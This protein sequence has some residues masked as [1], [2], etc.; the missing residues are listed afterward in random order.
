MLY[1]CYIIIM[2][3]NTKK[4]IKITAITLASLFLAIVLIVGGYVGYVLASFYRIKD[5]QVLEVNGT[6]TAT[7]VATEQTLSIVT[8]N[9]GFGA[10]V[11]EYDFFMDEGKMADGTFTVGSHAKGISKKRVQEAVTG[12]ANTLAN[13]N[14][15]FIFMQEVDLNAD[16]SYHIDMVQTFRDKFNGMASAF[17]C[18]FHTPYLLYPFNDPIGKTKSGI[19]TFSKYQIQ[20]SVRRSFP[21]TDS[22]IDKQFDLDRC[23]SVSRVSV[24]GG[25]QLVLINLHMSAYDEGGTIRT[26]QLAMLNAVLAEEATLGNYVIVGGDFNH[27]LTADQYGSTTEAISAYKHGQQVP[28][29]IANSFLQG[30]DLASGYTINANKNTPTCRG[31][32]IPYTQGVTFEVVIDGFLTSSNITVESEGAIL[33]GYEYSDH[34]P[35][36]MTFRLNG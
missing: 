20:S 3:S 7:T 28:D 25:K 32:D 8:Y 1:L 5:N 6:A 4:I 29:W 30:K 14:A 35:V 19:L 2:K 26:Q 31:A 21:I 15:D 34:N 17:A 22:L 13:A 12:Q 24:Q 18:N 23:F 16:R 33:S 10:Y 11:P 36:K 27:C 9:V